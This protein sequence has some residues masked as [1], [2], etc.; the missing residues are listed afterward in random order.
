MA[1]QLPAAPGIELGQHPDETGASHLAVRRPR[2]HR[3][4]LRGS[5]APIRQDPVRER[6]NPVKDNPSGSARRL[7]S[8]PGALAD[9]EVRAAAGRCAVGSPA[10]GIGLRPLGP[11]VV[12]ALWT[13]R[14]DQR[15]AQKWDMPIGAKQHAKQLRAGSDARRRV[16]RH[17]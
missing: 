11:A 17:R 5:P 3:G 10:I 6:Q 12:Q 14:A 13:T 8:V 16:F 15:G 4:R 1:A 2:P 9:D 7:G